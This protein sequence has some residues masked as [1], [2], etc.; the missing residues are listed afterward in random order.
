VDF[1]NRLKTILPVRWFES[2][3]TL[4]D[5]PTPVLDGLL[6]GPAAMYE[7]TNLHNDYVR[8]QTRITTATD[9]YLD[10]I[11]QDFCGNS[12]IR[13]LNEPDSAFSVRLKFYILREKVT[14]ASIDAICYIL[15]GHHPIIFEPRDP[16]DTGGYSSVVQ[17]PLYVGGGT[18][19]GVAGGYGSMIL[20]NQFFICVFRPSNINRIPNADGWGGSIGGWGVGAIEWGSMKSFIPLATDEEIDAAIQDTV[21]CPNIAWMQIVDYGEVTGIGHH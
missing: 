4:R 11:A 18:G 14:R 15:T 1:L 2:S 5:S 7:V 20:A 8:L 16:G 10:I 6:S 19:Y 3:A 12:V 17:V 21:M 13:R 9:I